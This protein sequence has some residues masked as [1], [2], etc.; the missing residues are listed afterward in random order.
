MRCAPFSAGPP[1]RAAI[2]LCGGLA[3]RHHDQGVREV[4]VRLPAGFPA[5]RAVKHSSRGR[6]G[7]RLAG[8]SC[9]ARV[10]NSA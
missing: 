9:L 8:A 2:Q 4:Y 7:A 10:R 1:A 5:G 3:R 6:G